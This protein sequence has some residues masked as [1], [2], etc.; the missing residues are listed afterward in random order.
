[1]T[2]GAGMIHPNLGTML[3]YLV[4]DADLEQAQLHSLLKDVVGNSF[5]CLTVDG[6]TSP[7]DKVFLASTGKVKITWNDETLAGFYKGLLELS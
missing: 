7:N 5:N 2:K 4:T 3:A 1:M 6:D